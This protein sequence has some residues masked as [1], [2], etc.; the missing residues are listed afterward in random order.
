MW[1]LD[2]RPRGPDR[3]SR[4]TSVRQRGGLAQA[5]MDDASAGRRMHGGRGAS[6]ALVR[7]E[8]AA[9]TTPCRLRPAQD[10][11]TRPPARPRQA[12][13]RRAEKGWTSHQAWISLLLLRPHCLGNNVEGCD[14]YF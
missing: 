8:P 2:E 3:A 9:K 4:R 6:A 10:A 11:R 1:H 7:R 13:R 14:K 12:G 5:R